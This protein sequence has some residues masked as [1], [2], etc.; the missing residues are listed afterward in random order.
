MNTELVKVN[1]R[2]FKK[3]ISA[4]EISAAVQEIATKINR[5]FDGESVM[6]LVVLKGSMI[7]A[8]DLVRHITIPVS[9]E[10]VRARSYGHRMETTGKVELDF[11]EIDFKDKNIIIVEDIVDSGL[12]LQA[13]IAWLLKE[14]PKSVNVAALLSKPEVRRADVDVKYCGIEIPPV[15]VVGYGLD[16][17]EL[18]RNLPEIYALAE[19]S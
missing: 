2:F 4:E 18:G 13:L 19:A 1:D 10:T 11:T 5:D 6:L 7:F 16:Y 15:F 9:M 12:T 8:A 14:A 17:A 3:Y